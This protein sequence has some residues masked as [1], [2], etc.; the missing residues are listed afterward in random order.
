M[1]ETVI[2]KCRCRNIGTSRGFL[3]KKSDLI[4]KDQVDYKVTIEEIS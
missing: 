2:V 3:I 4:L 1:P